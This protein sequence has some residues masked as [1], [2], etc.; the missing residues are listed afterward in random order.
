R[1]REGELSGRLAEVGLRGGLY[2]VG[3]A[4]E[5]DGVEVVLEDLVLGEL[6]VDLQGENRLPELADV[7]GRRAQVVA[8]DVLLGERRAALDRVAAQ[9]VPQ[10][11][12]DGDRVDADVLV[13]AAEIG[14]AHV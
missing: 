1:L 2:T 7:V 11:A 3:V 8:L 5:V 14:R 9:V 12:A 13:E 4:A 6:A 10:R